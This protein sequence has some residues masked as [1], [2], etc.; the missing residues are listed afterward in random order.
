M[1]MIL[2]M[3]MYVHVYVYIYIYTHIKDYVKPAAGPDFAWMYPFAP[4]LQAAEPRAET[5]PHCEHA[6]TYYTII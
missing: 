4:R 3:C 2:C 5:I 6:S 1:H